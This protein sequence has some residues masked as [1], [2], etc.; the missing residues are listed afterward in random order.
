MAGPF[1]E[2][3]NFRKLQSK[4]GGSHFALGAMSF[5]DLVAEEKRPIIPVR[6]Y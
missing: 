2:Q 5:E 6:P 3:L 4:Q 1:P